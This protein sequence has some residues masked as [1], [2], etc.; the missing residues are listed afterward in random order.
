[1]GGGQAAGA[2]VMMPTTID[3]GTGTGSDTEASCEDGDKRARHANNK[4][5]IIRVRKSVVALGKE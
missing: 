2:G 1:M 4:P 3:W 5:F